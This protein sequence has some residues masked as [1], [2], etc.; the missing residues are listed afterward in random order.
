MRTN[1]VLDDVLVTKALKV[2]GLKTKR[3]L[4]MAALKEFIQSH[5]QKDIREL[6]GNVTFSRGYDYKK[7]REGKK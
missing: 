3:A 5:S 6:K 1:I 4:I 2:S 7:L